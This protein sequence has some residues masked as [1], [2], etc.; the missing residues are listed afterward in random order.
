MSAPLP[1][2]PLLLP[3][4]VAALP[5][6]VVVIDATGRVIFT[7]LAAEQLLGGS[8]AGQ[9]WRDWVDRHAGSDVEGVHDALRLGDRWLAVTTHPLSRGQLVVVEDVSER[10]A[11]QKIWQQQHHQLL[12]G[13]TAAELAHQ[14]RTPVATALL[15]ASQIAMFEGE[16]Q[17][18]LIDRTLQTLEGLERLIATMLAL[19]RGEGEALAPLHLGDLWQRLR[20]SNQPRAVARGVI[21]TASALEVEILTQPTLLQSALQNLIDNALAVASRRID[22]IAEWQ[23]GGRL[24]LA[25]V[26]DGPGLA[27]GVSTGGNGIGL[28]VARAIARNLHGEL[29]LLPLACGSR[30]ELVLDIAED[31]H[32]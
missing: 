17:Q 3:E 30:C 11:R 13:R 21:L 31:N 1:S 7:N 26:D 28:E 4:V 14:L 25:V 16:V 20:E 8:L 15:Y 12:L 2:L 6:A 22:L 5:Q 10:V 32:V 19:A 24:A 18:R 9:L 29:R 23:T 27:A